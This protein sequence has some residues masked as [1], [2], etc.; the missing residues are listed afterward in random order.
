MAVGAQ[1]GG[2]G[3]LIAALAAVADVGGFGIDGVAD[4]E[5]DDGKGHGAEDGEGQDGRAGQGDEEAADADEVANGGEAS[6]ATTGDFARHA[7]G[8]DGFVSG[9][10]N[11]MDD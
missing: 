1:G 2:F 8:L 11:R 7:P 10:H 4:G 9:F 3:D 5:E 6:A